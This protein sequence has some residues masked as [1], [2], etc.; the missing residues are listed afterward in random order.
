[1][2]A[3]TGHEKQ[4]R[5][6]SLV[7][8][9]LMPVPKQG[10]QSLDGVDERQERFLARFIPN[11]GTVR[12]FIRSLI[13]DR[14]TCDDVFQE[15]AL[16]LWREFDR[17]DPARPFGPWARGVAARTI[18]MG[19]RQTR[20]I[21]VAMSPEAI[22]ALETAFAAFDGPTSGEEEALRHCVDRLPDKSRL[23]VR[24]RYR[25]SLK[26]AEIASRIGSSTEA[27]QKALTRLRDALQRCVQRRM[28]TELEGT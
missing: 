21:P 7:S 26:V 3:E 12:A 6:V 4:H 11:Q 19:L 16:V 9:L 20:R 18:R 22:E 24:L 17:Y 1:V 5:I 13:W 25:E 27:A 14:V 28:R 8:D 23:L 10:M 2:R 15:V